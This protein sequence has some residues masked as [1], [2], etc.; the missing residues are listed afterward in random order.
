MFGKLHRW[1]GL[2]TAGFLFLSGIT[3]AII[4]WDHKL[5]ELLNRKFH[6]VTS[7]GP[8]KSSLDLAALIERR[9]PR[10][11]VNFFHIAP[12]P[13]ASLSFFVQPR[14][15]PATGK[16]FALDYN[17]IFLDP[18]TGA[19]LG[20]RSWGAVWP[21]S[22]EN[23]VS[24]LYK[25]HYTLH[26]P[27]FWGS[28]RW[29]IRLLGIIAIIWTI[30]CFV[31]FYLTLPQRR[32]AR[33]GRAPAVARELGRGFWARWAPAWTIK[34]RGSAYR[35]NFDIHRAFSLWTWA[36]LFAI[37]FTG[38]SL[39]LYFEVF[40]PI[41]KTVSDYTPTPFEQRPYRDLDDPI[42]PKVG[43]AEILARAAADGRSRGWTTPVGSLFYGPAHGVYA[44]AFF[45]PGD[46]HG[47]GGV[48]PAQLYYDSEDGRP[49]GERLPWRGTAADVFVQLQF[50]THSGRILGLPGRILISI[51]GLVVA[52][53]SVTGVVIWWRKRR[54]RVRVRSAGEAGPR[55]LAAAE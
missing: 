22:R 32:R 23:F 51:M 7:S 53:L 1:A 39:N 29:G 42:E 50:P 15:D 18:N 25:L 11:R 26:I 31:G 36:L 48:A 13:G 12:E 5:D 40:S 44:V 2:L 4:S 14:I 3:G 30:D 41:M 43:F 38:F 19:E 27:E 28:D 47:A 55:Q 46:D 33:A 49:I 10:A 34:T 6:D 17:Q 52:A 9:D 45:H 16:R 35:I 20:R 21:L 54:A 37:A 8:T 24:F